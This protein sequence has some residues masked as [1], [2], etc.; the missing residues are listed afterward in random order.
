M[1]L[2]DL[3][4]RPVVDARGTPIGHV[5]DALLVQDGPVI[6]G[7]GAQPRIEGLAVGKRSI[8]VR[9]GYHRAGVRGPA[10]VRIQIERLAPRAREVEWADVASKDDSEVRL[11]VPAGELSPPPVV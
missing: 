4:D 6:G 2:S 7:F 8:A 9:L 1:L 5:L 11:R 3:L 10:P